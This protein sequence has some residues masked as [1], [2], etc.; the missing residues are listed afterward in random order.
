MNFINEIIS[1]TILLVT[2]K[3]TS[4]W[5]NILLLE[6]SYWQIF[7]D[8]F[9]VSIIFYYI[10]RLLK[11]SRTTHVL[12]GLVIIAVTYLLSQALGLFALKWLL[13]KF[14]TFLI[15]AIPILFQQELRRGLEKLGQQT[16]FFNMNRQ[17]DVDLLINEVVSACSA[18]RKMKKG[19]LIVFRRKDLLKEYVDTGTILDS[20]LNKE[21]II[22]IFANKSPLHDGAVIIEN[23]KIKAAGCILPHTFR[24]YSSSFGTRH[25]AALGI[26]EMTDAVVIS[27][28]EEQGTISFIVNEKLTLVDEQQL[29]DLLHKHLV[30]NTK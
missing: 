20:K 30:T 29:E 9:L 12:I 4:F 11:G 17:H 23:W 21:L 1:K 19:A 26:S 15:V 22:S 27:I 10:S 25:K 3:T 28:S 13:D 6:I 18:I 7:L 16:N 24:K 14:M 2:E 8:I 5:E